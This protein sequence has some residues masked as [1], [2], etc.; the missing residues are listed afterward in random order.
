[1]TGI[2]AGGRGSGSRVAPVRRVRDV[3]RTRVLTG[4]YGNRPLPSEAALAAELGAS[5]NVV[6]DVLALLRMEGLVD[7]IPGVGTLV[8]SGKAVQGLD[9]LRGLAESF[10]TGCD[11]VVNQVLLAD[12]VPAT[13]TVAERLEVTPGTEVIALE[14]VR[15]LDDQPLSLDASY[16]PADI[17]RPL[18]EMDLTRHDVFGLIEGELGLCLGAAALSIEA[19]A[20]DRT[21]AG[22]LR[23]PDG[24][25]LLFLERLTYTDAGR[26]IDLEFVRFRGDRMSLS[27]WLHR[28]PD[29]HSNHPYSERG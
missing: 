9:R 15:M 22:L 28:T 6:R 2:T 21:V 12:T 4:V 25:P 8:V 29:P 11:R 1:M 18:L 3:L 26:P 10:D 20:A 7:R 5:R 19:I 13:P 16:L 14:R 23:V 17:G 24:F 27:A